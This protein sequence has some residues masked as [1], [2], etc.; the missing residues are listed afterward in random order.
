MGVVTAEEFYNNA[1]DLLID[2][3][4]IQAEI[5]DMYSNGETSDGGENENKS[6]GGL[7]GGISISEIV[8]SV[9]GVDRDKIKSLDKLL[10]T[11]NELTVSDAK[12]EAINSIGD[13]IG[14]LSN[15]IDTIDI[16]RA[17]E[18]PSVLRG[19][20]LGIFLF[21]VGLGASIVLLGASVLA[22]P[23]GIIAL[24]GTI[25][26]FGLTTKII[27]DNSSDINKGSL[28]VGVMG[29]SLIVF[30]GSMAI[31]T[32][33][34]TSVNTEGLLML[35]LL[36][37]G[38]S[39]LYYFVGKEAITILEGSLAV[40]GMALSL[41]LLASPMVTIS[42][43]IQDGSVLWKLPLLLGG[44]GLSYAGIG[45]LMPEILLGAVA[46]GA[47][48]ASL[49]VIGKGL[50]A[51]TDIKADSDQV[52]EVTESIVALVN[53][54]GKLSLVDMLTLP[55]K[56][57]I[58]ALMGLSLVPLSFGI[59]KFVN[60]TKG[61][62]D[63]EIDRLGYTIT[64]LS[65]AYALAGSTEG[66]TQ[67]F[68]FNVGRNDVERGIDSTLK[69]GRN[70]NNLS[71]GIKAWRD[72]KFTKKDIEIIGNNV[73]GILN[74]IPAIFADVGARERGSSNQIKLPMFGNVQFG[75][76][77][78]KTD[79]ELGISS[80]MEIGSNLI[81]LHKGVMVWK[82]GKITSA[83]VNLIKDNVQAVLAVIPSIFAGIGLME[84]GSSNQIKFGGNAILGAFQFSMPF[85]KTDTE[86]GISVSKHMGG[87]LKSLHEG[88]YAWRTG[89]KNDISKQIGGIIKNIKMVL[90]AIPEAFK[91]VGDL[92]QQGSSFFG[93]VD[94]NMEDGVELVDRMTKPLK[95]VSN[96]I[97]NYV[98]D[99]DY[100]KG[101]RNLTMSLQSLAKGMDSFTTKR[102]D[103]MDDLNDQFDD[104]NKNLKEHFKIIKTIPKDEL[105]AFD[106][107]SK[108]LK[109]LSEVDVESLQKGL[110]Y[111]NQYVEDKR[112][113]VQAVYKV[114]PPVVVTRQAPEAQQNSEKK[115]E[116]KYNN[117]AL[118]QALLGASS[119][120]KGVL[121]QI[122]S[123]LKNGTL[124]VV[125]NDV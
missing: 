7:S 99:T 117:D 13:S 66:M 65:Q 80:T 101:S 64:G 2:I 36:L 68:G 31:S 6:V 49:W 123:H 53:G 114:P 86:L 83:E 124:K 96:L 25:A 79:T 105:L 55:M 52:T 69:M 107:Y 75:M 82:K 63:S 122:L 90:T 67:I 50:K 8:N 27:G 12:V 15:K 87:T 21:S 89:G 3:R 116:K 120:Q 29:L 60:D 47:M 104:L 71:T 46:A 54:L 19:I 98:G 23:V 91:E 61:F 34:I 62:D 4:D 42:E 14:N 41:W 35:P 48:G 92:A 11:I 39:L 70:L 32:A 125:E 113:T 51:I 118:L 73:A 112:Q 33:L 1:L 38:M 17:K 88:V 93:M 103:A 102:I 111:H 58:I 76:P 44:L 18:I 115:S 45:L 110:E 121:M 77:F 94:G 28:A 74:I 20:G 56:M 95:D 109:L 9:N 22:N 30:S 37:G 16:E 57:P 40:A 108:S 100:T 59:S 97:K 10:G 72:A 85:T 24:A 5:R 26:L 106:D 81:N 78:T 84:R 119:E 43:A